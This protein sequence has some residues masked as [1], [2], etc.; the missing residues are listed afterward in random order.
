MYGASPCVEARH[1]VAVAGDRLTID[2]AGLRA[3]PC[4]SFHDQREAVCEVI[5]GAAVEPHAVAVLAGDDAEAVVLDLVQ[6]T[7]HHQRV[8][9]E[10]WSEDR[11]ERSQRANAYTWPGDNEQARLEQAPAA[12]VP[13]M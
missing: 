3:Y 6:P 4:Q 2:D 13:G 11:A 7:N 1:A 9:L 5:A 10:L 12:P 8:A